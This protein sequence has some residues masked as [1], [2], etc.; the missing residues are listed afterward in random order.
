M[1]TLQPQPNNFQPSIWETNPKLKALLLVL[2]FVFLFSGIGLVVFAQWGG[3]YRQKIYD[4]TK[5]ALPKHAVSSSASQPVSEP[6]STT[7]PAG[8]KIYKND[9]YGFE[10]SYPGNGLLKEYDLT[11][12][13]SHGDAPFCPDKVGLPGCLDVVV[14]FPDGSEFDYTYQTVEMG[15]DLSDN[16]HTEK[17]S[18][19]GKDYDILIDD[20]GNAAIHPDQETSLLFFHNSKQKGDAVLFKQIFSTF[21]FTD[22]VSADTSTW[23]TYKNNEYGFEIQYPSTLEFQDCTIRADGSEPG[24][25]VLA[26][27]IFN[28]QKIC[29]VN[30]ASEW[31]ASAMHIMVIDAEKDP[32]LPKFGQCE[33]FGEFVKT[34][35]ISGINMTECSS[36]YFGSGKTPVVFFIHNKL[37]LNI[38]GD[39]VIS[40]NTDLFLKQFDSM[41]K[42][43]KFTK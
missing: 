24:L 43:F 40:D 3:A 35:N 6:A 22:E 15:K 27:Y 18:L 32:N 7:T 13:K 38:F 30:G 10:F 2:I 37:W 14:T 16:V 9:K 8:W 19:N 25:P 23:K 26:D 11:N 31:P 17:I 41:I 21:K 28:T 5:A 39:S 36:T 1:D 42:T 33:G 12:Q 34:F 4:E 20:Y 29:P